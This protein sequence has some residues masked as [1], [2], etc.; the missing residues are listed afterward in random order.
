MDSLSHGAQKIMDLLKTH[1]YRHQEYLPASRLHYIFD[2][3]EEKARSVDELVT[4]GLVTV[5]G[6]G[7]IGITPAGVQWNDA[8]R[9]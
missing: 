3:P 1:N 8:A 5:A 2:D 9:V 7:A 4:L 6:N